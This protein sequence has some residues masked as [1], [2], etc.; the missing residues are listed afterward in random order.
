MPRNDYAFPFRIDS[1]SGQAR[2]V[3]FDDH[4]EQMVRQVLLTDPGERIDLP[5]FGCG[6]RRLVFAPLSDALTSTTQLL[7]MQALDKWLANEVKVQ[8]VSVTQGGDVPDGQL[9]IQ[10][11][12]VVLQT[13]TL[14]HTVVQVN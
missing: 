5:E 12:Y 13:Q 11:D 10:I 3:G 2:R 7:V 4:I 14:R 1:S 8:N 9:L 6:L